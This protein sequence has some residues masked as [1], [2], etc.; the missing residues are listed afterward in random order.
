MIMHKKFA[1]KYI[2]VCADFVK[3]DL[4]FLKINVTIFYKYNLNTNKILRR[5][6]YGIVAACPQNSGTASIMLV[7]G[8]SS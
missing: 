1:N 7:S 3:K 6:R 2:K 5:R 4:T 8:F